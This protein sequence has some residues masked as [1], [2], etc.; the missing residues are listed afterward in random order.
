MRNLDVEEGAE[1]G[2]GMREFKQNPN[3]VAEVSLSLVRLDV[4]S[5]RSTARIFF[6]AVIFNNRGLAIFIRN[7]KT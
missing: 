7:N 5:A 6:P 2:D 1:D 3:R 4:L